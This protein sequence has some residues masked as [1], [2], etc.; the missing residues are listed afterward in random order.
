MVAPSVFFLALAF[1]VFPDTILAQI[2][3]GP[4]GSGGPVA[5]AGGGNLGGWNI[6]YQM[7]QG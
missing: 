7:P 5:P 6:E 4:P 1:L 2:A 3:G